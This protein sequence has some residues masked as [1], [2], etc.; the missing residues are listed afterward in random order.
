MDKYRGGERKIEGREGGRPGEREGQ[1]GDRE[2][3]WR[4]QNEHMQ[5]RWDECDQ[6][7]WTEEVEEQM[8][9]RSQGGVKRGE[10]AS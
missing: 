6:D 4:D 3:T 9:G 7:R 10:D 5:V 1:V 2:M 8:E